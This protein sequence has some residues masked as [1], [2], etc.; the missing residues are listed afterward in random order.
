LSITKKK[1]RLSVQGIVGFA[2]GRYA[3]EQAQLERE[4]SPSCEEKNTAF[5]GG[6]EGKTTSRSRRKGVLSIEESARG[7]KDA[8]REETLIK[9]AP[10]SY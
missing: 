5:A 10:S 7:E 8:A 1:K 3:G 9:K 4:E 2:G 6:K